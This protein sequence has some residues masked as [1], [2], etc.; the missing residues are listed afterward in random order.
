MGKSNLLEALVLIATGKS[1]RSEKEQQLLSFGQL[2]GR[3]KAVLGD[4]GEETKVEIIFIQQDT[5]LRKKYLVNG[6]AKRRTGFFGHLTTVLFTPNDLAIV[7]GQPS[8]RRT[9]LNE[10][11]E[12]V[13]QEYNEALLTYARALRQRNALLENVRTTGKRNQELFTYWDNLLIKNGQLLTKR[14]EELIDC[15]NEHEKRFFP[16]TITYDKSSISQER[17]QQYR[18]E[19]VRA[20]VTLVGPHRDDFILQTSNLRTQNEQR[21]LHNVKYFASRGQQRLVVLELKLAQIAFM[22]EQSGQQP[23]LLL[24]DIFSELDSM[25]IEKVLALTKD[26]QTVMTTTHREFI[27]DINENAAVIELN[28]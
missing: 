14:R 11:L 26:C 22:T 28:Q 7:I 27:S 25:H 1:Y 9:F 13:Y 6:V 24:D 16:F 4:T 21:E 23:L 3:I 12:Q 18:E 17:L 8:D 2:S 5:T 10:V 20:G 15:I 19:E